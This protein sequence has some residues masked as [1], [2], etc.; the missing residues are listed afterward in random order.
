MS[1]HE[2][3][4]YF[5]QFLEFPRQLLI[6]DMTSNQKTQHGAANNGHRYHGLIRK[7]SKGVFGYSRDKSIG[8]AMHNGHQWQVN[9]LWS[10]W[11]QRDYPFTSG[12]FLLGALPPYFTDRLPGIYTRPTDRCPVKNGKSTSFV[13]RQKSLHRNCHGQ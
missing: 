12:Q 2:K 8:F 1:R 13:R 3:I 6:N 5:Y 4:F 11:Y 10:L 7:S 9:T